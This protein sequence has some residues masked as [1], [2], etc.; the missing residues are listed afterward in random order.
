MFWLDIDDIVGDSRWLYD[1]SGQ[2]DLR[3]I[4]F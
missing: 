1:V 4:W 3:K 2:K